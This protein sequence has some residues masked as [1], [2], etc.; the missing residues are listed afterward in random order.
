MAAKSVTGNLSR[1]LEDEAVGEEHEQTLDVCALHR[2][3]S[4]AVKFMY[5][6]A[7]GLNHFSLSDYHL[8]YSA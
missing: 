8:L 1:P 5:G 6:S 2:P 3:L 7:V 4:V